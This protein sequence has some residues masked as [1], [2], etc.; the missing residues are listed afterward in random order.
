MTKDRAEALRG[1][2]S[3]SP[4]KY[5]TKHP[6]AAIEHRIIDSP[7][8]ADLTFSA[9]ALLVLLAR[10]ITATGNN[11][12]LQASFKWCSQRGFG[13][14]HT[15]RAAI[16]EL[17]AHGLIYRTRSHG[18]NGAWARYALTWIPISKDREGLFLAGFK[19]EAWR[20]WQPSE[21]KSS[22]QK[23]LDQSGRK[24]S[25][26]PKHPAE[27]AGSRGAKN[28]A[29]ELVASSST[30]TAPDSDIATQ[31][32]P[33]QQSAPKWGNWIPDYINRLANYGLADAC[34]VASI[35]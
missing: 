19:P 1:R 14:E 30:A 7:A 35:H 16:A 9:Q 25:F 15:L 10:Q 11:G 27:T 23:L 24:C 29:Y 21:K 22:R 32:G 8:Y 28:A 33:P 2:G 31:E 5:A 12:H 13:S 20:D 17:I 34:P 18:A 3:Q 4:R 26:T 6:Y